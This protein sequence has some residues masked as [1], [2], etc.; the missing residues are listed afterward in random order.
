MKGIILSGG[1]GTRLYPLTKVLSKQILPVYNKPMIYYSLSVLMLAGIKDI[2]LISDRENIVL[3]EKLL[4]NGS[5]LGMNISYKV[6]EEPRGI[7]EAFLIGEEYIGR[8]NVA[9]ILGDNIFYGNGFTGKL[10]ES[11]NLENGAIIFP[12]YNKKPENFGVVEF[13]GERIISLEEKPKIPK[14]NY[15]VPGLY[16]F[17]N[18]VIEKAKNIVESKRGE[19]EIVS[20]LEKYLEEEKLYYK[21]LGRGMVWLDAGTFDGLLEA[22]N[23]IQTI[24]KQQGIMIGCLEEIAY[25][26]GWI[27]KEQLLKNIEIIENLEYG[28]YLKE[29]L[30]GME[31]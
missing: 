1:K 3:F 14:S 17:D 27:N 19:L 23:F 29:I 7:G 20:I 21:N 5:N 25:S 2:L 4:G 31:K 11:V 18:S 22:S 12:L 15:I 6:Q 9:L 30:K 10:K 16:F 28:K 8:D 26:N 24:E 13:K